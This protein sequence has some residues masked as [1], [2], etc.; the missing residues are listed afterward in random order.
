MVLSNPVPWQP[1]LWR[2]EL[3]DAVTFPAELG[4]VLGLPLE[5]RE[6]G[7]SGGFPLRVPRGFVARMRR[8]YAND[9][10]LRQVLPTT[11]EDESVSVPDGTRFS[12]D[13]VHEKDF[14]RADN[15]PEAPRPCAPDRDIGVRDPLPVGPYALTHCPL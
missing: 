3:K 11:A 2:S 6:N 10:L 14:T 15:D 1:H 5:E 13:P 4:R 8:N 9:P 7:A 12:V